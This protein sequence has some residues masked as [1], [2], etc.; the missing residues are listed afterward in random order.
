LRV[1]GTLRSVGV[2]IRSAGPT[3]KVL[4]IRRIGFT[5]VAVLAI[6][7]SASPALAVDWRPD[8]KLSS[9]M[10]SDHELLPTGPNS[11]IAV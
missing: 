5:T 6:A 1:L 11:A 4:T 7:L 8:I 9:T 3:M 10:T 2:G